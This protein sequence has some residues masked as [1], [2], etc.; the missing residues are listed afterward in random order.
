MPL[1]TRT[2]IRDR[3]DTFVGSQSL[4]QLEL[5]ARREI[6]IIFREHA[7]VK[8]LVRI[9][10]EDW[11]ASAAEDFEKKQ[12]SALLPKKA[13]K[14]VAESVAKTIS[15][16]PVAKRVTKAIRKRADIDVDDKAVRETVKQV[17]KD[18]V[19]QTAKHVAAITAKELTEGS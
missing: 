15:V 19:E 1:H 14:K 12:K 5:D 18:V 7:V 3:T 2:I 10:E 4:R 8:D 16:D 11:A 13:A 6:G 9:F 17:V